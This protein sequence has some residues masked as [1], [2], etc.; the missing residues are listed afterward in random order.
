MGSGIALAFARAGSAVIVMARTENSLER[1]LARVTASLGFLVEV[2]ELTDVRAAAA[3]ERVEITTD[4]GQAV[5]EADLV[6]E[7][8]PEDAD[9][10]R[11]VLARAEAA[12][13]TNAILGT[14]TSSLSIAELA[15][16][17]RAPDRFA[18]FHWF[19]PPELIDLVEVVSGPQ[20]S[21]QT[22]ATLLDWARAAGKTPIHVR[23]DIEGFIANRLQ[24]ALL[25]EAFA[26]VEEGV[27]FYQ[28]VDCAVT[29]GLGARWAAVGPFESMDL[30]GLDVHCEVARRLYPILASLDGPPPSVQRLVADGALGVKTGRGLYGTYTPDHVRRVTKRRDAVLLSL[31]RLR[32][33][34]SE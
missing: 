34:H 3:L 30:A 12:A 24:Y 4:L 29:A 1:A 26:L 16:A 22:A 11:D 6:V 25:R 21:E 19:N 18:G 7:S 31:S 8:V 32:A 10:K 14:D 33:S 5:G 17:L 23:R 27:C 13:P 9:V 20:T 28:D 2:G 15:R